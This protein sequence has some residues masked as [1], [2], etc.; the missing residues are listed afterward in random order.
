L[1]R[2][3]LIFFAVTTLSFTTYSQVVLKKI[4]VNNKQ[5]KLPKNGNIF[6]SV[7]EN[8]LLLEFNQ[9]ENPNNEYYYRLKVDAV[10]S[11]WIKSTYPVVHFQNLENGKY[12]FQFKAK[13]TNIF[14]LTITKEIPFYYET[15]FYLTLFFYIIIFIGVVIYLFILYDFRQKLRLQGVR[16]QIAA[17]LHDEVGSNLNSIAIFVE[18]LR[19]KASPDILPI[20]DKIIENS[21]E[22]VTLMQDTVWTINPKNDSVEKLFERMRSFASQY[23]A[24]V[25]IPLDFVIEADLKKV[26]FSMEQRKNIYLIFKEAINNIVK[27][28]QASKAS[29]LILK[30]DDK[31]Q[32]TINDNGKGFDKSIDFEGNGL[33]NFRNRAEEAEIECLIHSEINKGTNIEIIAFC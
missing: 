11:S 25:G 29:V 4:L 10:D 18:V 16:N 22:S 23:L 27:H 30:V 14:Q 21:K 32:I 17:D 8:D 12:I 33:N 19:Q 9:L 20:L 7:Q 28:S 13:K 15:W 26:N 1:L 24:N 5:I 31:L 3:L 2:L 6:L